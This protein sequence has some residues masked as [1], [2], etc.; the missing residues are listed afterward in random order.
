MGASCASGRGQDQLDEQLVGFFCVVFNIQQG[1]FVRTYSS[2][3]SQ[4][5]LEGGIGVGLDSIPGLEA[6]HLPFASPFKTSKEPV[7]NIIRR[8]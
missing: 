6:I 8:K 2:Y 3:D 4:R 5:E 7:K 1:D